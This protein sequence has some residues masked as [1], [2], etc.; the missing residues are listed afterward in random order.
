MVDGLSSLH[1]DDVFGSFYTKKAQENTY[2]YFHGFFV[3]SQQRYGRLLLT[4][5]REYPTIV[6][7]IP[8]SKL[9]FCLFQEPHGKLELA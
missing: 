6:L 1:A 2:P 8:L 9:D 7:F 3:S 4:F 5:Y